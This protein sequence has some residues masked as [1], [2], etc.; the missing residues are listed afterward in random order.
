M[1]HRGVARI[2]EA[3]F[4]AILIIEAVSVSYYLLVAP[5]PGTTRSS[6]ELSKFGYS[7]LSSLAS[8]NGFDT[9]LFDSAGNIREGWENEFK[10]IMNSLVPPNIIFNIT[11]YNATIN[12]STGFVVLEKINEVPISNVVSEDAFIKAGEDVQVTYVYTTY[13]SERDEIQI[14]F[15]YLELAVLRGA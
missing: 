13:K 9:M 15:I 11:V 8:N 12:S 3:V 14:Y 5:N 2:V 10:V 1:K 4:S 7:L 6:E